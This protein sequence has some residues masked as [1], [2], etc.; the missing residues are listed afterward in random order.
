MKRHPA[1]PLEGWHSEDVKAAIRKRGVTLTGLARR[2]RLSESYLR[3]VLLRP[4]P[5]GEEIIARFIGVPA[6]V[7]WPKRYNADGTPKNRRR[8]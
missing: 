5:R 4:L 7:I 2:N 3:N 8:A 1:Q 6:H